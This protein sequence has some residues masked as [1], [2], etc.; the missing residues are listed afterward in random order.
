MAKI[1]PFPKVP[2]SR[3]S[4]IGRPGRKYGNRPAATRR[5]S[6]FSIL[7]AALW[8]FVVLFF[9]LIKVI[10]GFDLFILGVRAIYFWKTPDAHDGLV[11][12]LHGSGYLALVI[13]MFFYDHKKFEQASCDRDSTCNRSEA[14]TL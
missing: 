5:R 2:R 6:V 12:L 4:N 14:K 8:V 7:V 11:F 9:P 1:I 3:I 10:A 13:F